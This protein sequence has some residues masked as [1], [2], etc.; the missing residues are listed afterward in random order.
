M[1][2]GPL[3]QQFQEDPRATVAWVSGI[4]AVYVAVGLARPRWLTRRARRTPRQW[5][6]RIMVQALVVTGFQIWAKPWMERTQ[7][8]HADL[9]AEL[10]REPTWEEVTARMEQ[11]EA[12]RS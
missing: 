7:Q 8:V 6:W 3:R 11:V 9:T 5:L 1:A 4:A 12:D 10:G 2:K